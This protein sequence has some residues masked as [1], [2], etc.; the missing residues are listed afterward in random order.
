MIANLVVR[1]AKYPG[2]ARAVDFRYVR[3]GSVPDAQYTLAERLLSGAYQPLKVNI[4]KTTIL[5]VC[6]HQ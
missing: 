5:S 6:F 4:E 2:P 1:L 3:F